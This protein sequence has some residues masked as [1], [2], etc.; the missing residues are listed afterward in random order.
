V[1]RWE[2][3]TQNASLTYRA[4]SLE[5][6]ID[7]LPFNFMG[8]A[9]DGNG[10]VLM[11][12]AAHGALWSPE[13]LVTQ[14]PMNEADALEESADVT[15]VGNSIFVLGF[16]GDIRTITAA[17]GSEEWRAAG[18][19]G[20]GLSLRTSQ[21]LGVD[22]LLL[23][24]GLRREIKGI[25][26]ATARVVVR[27]RFDYSEMGLL[28]DAVFANGRLYAIADDAIYV[29]PGPAK[30]SDQTCDTPP[31]D[32]ALPRPLLYGEDVLT[33]TQGFLYPISGGT[34]PPWPRVY[35]GAS[36]IYRM[37]VHHGVDVYRYNGPVGFGEGYP[38][39][40]MAAGY[41]EKASIG[42]EQMTEDE[43]QA[44]LEQSEATGETPPAILERLEGKR[45][46]IDHGNG[47][48]SVYAH[49]DQVAAGVVAGARIE[50]GQIIGAVG[51]TGTQAEGEPGTEA[52]HLHFELWV[53]ERYLG[54]GL[55]LRETMWW[56]ERIF[57]DAVGG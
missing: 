12:D 23:V 31:D 5:E 3:A 54:K 25:D 30:P 39:I 14:E 52:P 26:P 29:Y 47:V 50:A 1:I 13:G 10:R 4:A 35:P 38:V 11:L 2:P 36:R 45:V 46:I 33:L 40:A 57:A 17:V 7:N 41:V 27:Y 8:I 9:L 43:F 22:L 16:S 18:E 24:D 55:T 53:G 34:L 42:Y 48:R 28:R 49:L 6:D 56:F 32:L 20:L 44:M 51:V 15:T 19:T 21:H 37:G